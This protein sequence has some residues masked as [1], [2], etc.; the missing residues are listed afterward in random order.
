MC[1]F[2]SR[3]LNYHELTSWVLK[4][5]G[6]QDILQPSLLFSV[7]LII[8]VQQKKSNNQVSWSR[9]NEAPAPALTMFRTKDETYKVRVW[10]KSQVSLYLYEIR[11]DE[12]LYHTCQPSRFSRET[13]DFI[14]LSRFPPGVI[15]LP[16]SDKIWFTQDCFHSDFNTATPL[17][18]FH[19]SVARATES[20][21]GWGR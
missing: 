2:A 6:K 12:V 1:S 3:V 7:L 20:L 14:A 10:S 16:I 4:E 11:W 18:G 13:P 8:V 19:G 9:L 17:F 21:R 5:R 15:F